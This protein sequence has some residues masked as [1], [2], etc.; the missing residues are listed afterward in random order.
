[1]SQAGTP[2]MTFDGVDLRYPTGTQ[3]L[4]GVSLELQP[5]HFVA[6]VG[7]SGCGKSTLLRL[8]ARLLAPSAGTISHGTDNIGFVFQDP[9]L[10]PW[11]TVRGNVELLGEL[12]GLPAAAR[13]ARSTEALHRVGLTEAAHQRPATLSGGM[14][15]RA[16]LARTLT[17]APDLFLFDEPFAAVDEITRSRLGDDLQQ[18]FVADRFAALFVTH[19]VAEAVYLSSRVLVMST[20]PGRIVGEVTVPAAYPR[21]PQWRYTAEFAAL[22]AAVVAHLGREAAGDAVASTPEGR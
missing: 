20:R 19:S 11:R 4:A 3:A 7:P 17:L 12:R 2:L 10:L 6:V 1:V 13:R 22:T 8:A 21:P 5:A 16:S 18:L 9:T 14:R 15:M